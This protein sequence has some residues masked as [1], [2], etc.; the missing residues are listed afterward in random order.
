MDTANAK[1]YKLAPGA[2][3]AELFLEHQSLKGIDGS[4]FLDHTIY[5]N[6]VMTKSNTS[7]QLPQAA[8]EEAAH[9][10]PY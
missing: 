6:N 2:S 9:H 1:I 3:T 4:T 5:V 8:L 10:Q 7:L